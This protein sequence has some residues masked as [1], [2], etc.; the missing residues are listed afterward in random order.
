HD[1]SDRTSQSF[2]VPFKEIKANDWDLSINSYKEIVYEEVVYDAPKII[3]DRITDT[4]KERS[5][6]MSNLKSNL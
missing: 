5:K 3:I 1:Y 6:L 4:E 2:L